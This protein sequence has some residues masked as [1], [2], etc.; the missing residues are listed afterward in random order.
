MAN[1]VKTLA[2]SP[3]RATAGYLALGTIHVNIAGTGAPTI[4]KIRGMTGTTF[5]R[6]SA[7]VY[8]VAGLPLCQSLTLQ[9]NLRHAAGV[10]L[11]AVVTA[12][13]AA[14]GTA[15]ITCL[16]GTVTTEVPTGG[17]FDILAIMELDS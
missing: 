9:V 4:D 6:S 8:A 5:T 13:D 14:A 12:Q 10:D 15:T 7:G 3:A 1:H 2:R 16:T 17:V 11:Y